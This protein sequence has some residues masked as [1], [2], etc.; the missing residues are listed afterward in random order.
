VKPVSPVLVTL[1]IITAIAAVIGLGWSAVRGVQFF[2]SHHPYSM[3]NTSMTPT[4]YKGDQIMLDETAYDH[5]AMELGDIIAFRHNGVVLVKRVVARGGDTVEISGNKLRLNGSDLD[6][7]YAHYD[8]SAN[9]QIEQPVPLTKIP[10]DELFV[11]G[12]WRT[13]SLDSRS[14]ENFGAVH[15]ND[16]IGKV[17]AIGVSTIPGQSGRTF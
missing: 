13:R 14:R 16:V 7:P 5:H 15:R 8:D 10:S 3:T 1:G 11:M 2:R 9:L 12:D 4:I 6:E 17:V